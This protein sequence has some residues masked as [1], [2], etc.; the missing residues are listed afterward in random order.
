[1]KKIKRKIKKKAGK[2]LRR[3]IE[4]YGFYVATKESQEMLLEHLAQPDKV[5]DFVLEANGCSSKKSKAQL[6]QDIVALIVNRFKK[7][8]YFVEFGATNGVDLSN[9]FLLEQEFEWRGILAEPSPAWH[10]DLRKNRHC[11]IEERCVWRTTGENLDF[12]VVKIGE[13][14]TISSFSQSDLH[15]K[16]RA[17]AT[18][19]VVKTVSLLDLLTTHSAPS[20]IDYL[21]VDT[22]G[23]EY[24]ILS[25]F[26]FD[27]F[28]FNF[29]TVEHN[30][31][32]N[33]ERIHALLRRNGYKRILECLSKWDDWYV[34]DAGQ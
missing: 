26:D 31:T 34:V 20:L 9:T 1:M 22:E 28:R 24:E 30:Y 10:A 11:V 33:R 6:K 27:K 7:G 3:L 19:H 21:S 13:L 8:G 5:L 17:T 25:A 4:R 14:S 32:E 23:S 16:A 12:D 18:K 15:A 29:I 2:I